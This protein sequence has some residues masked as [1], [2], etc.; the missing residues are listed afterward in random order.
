MQHYDEV[1]GSS[2][3]EFSRKTLPSKRELIRRWRFFKEQDESLGVREVAKQIAGELVTIWNT[4]KI[5]QKTPN[6]IAVGIERFLRKFFKETKKEER[7]ESSFQVKLILI[8]PPRFSR[9]V[10]KNSLCPRISNFEPVI[11]ASFQGPRFSNGYQK[12]GFG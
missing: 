12:N 4:T 7:R 2:L 1:A 6:A 8:K 3:A 9:M 5:P 10:S 11:L